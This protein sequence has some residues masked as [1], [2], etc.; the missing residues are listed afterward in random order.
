MLGTIARLRMRIEVASSFR[1]S[2]SGN[3]NCYI[4]PDKKR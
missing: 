4:S 3:F 2:V 1:P